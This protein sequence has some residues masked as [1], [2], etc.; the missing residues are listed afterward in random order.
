MYYRVFV[1][2]FLF[3]PVITWAD[4]STAERFIE[5]FEDN[6]NSKD[7]S[8]LYD[9]MSNTY[10]SSVELSFFS[11]NLEKN[12][13]RLISMNKIGGGVFDNSA[14]FILKLTYNYRHRTYITTEVIFCNNYAGEWEAE[15]FPFSG[16]GIVNFV[17]NPLK[18]PKNENMN[19]Q[20][21]ERTG[22]TN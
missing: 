3:I 14:Y 7:W 2:F 10:R 17:E 19:V 5:S 18:G 21:C 6:L 11:E 15:N 9:S 4:S 22:P 13:F 20:G 12:K 8:E 16:A 1:I